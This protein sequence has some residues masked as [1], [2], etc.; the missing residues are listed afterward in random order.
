MPHGMAR[1]VQQHNHP[2]SLAAF[3]LLESDASNGNIDHNGDVDADVDWHYDILLHAGDLAY[4]LHQD[5]GSVGDA[6]MRDVQP[7]A[8][9]TPFM[10]SPG[11]HEA[12]AN[13]SHFK[14]RFT[15]PLLKEDAAA[16]ENLWWSVDV[17]MVHVVSYNTEAYFDGDVNATV[18]A[19]Y[20]WLKADLAA[21]QANRDAVPCTHAFGRILTEKN[22]PLKVKFQRKGGMSNACSGPTVRYGMIIDD[23]LASYPV[24]TRFQT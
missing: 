1:E 6:F 24:G 22:P 17:G 10:V 12:F 21:A 9:T 20:N 16:A 7:I 18:E 19:Q 3:A 15:M 4:D 8:S 11:N 14:N 13:F 23:F 2:I 5:A